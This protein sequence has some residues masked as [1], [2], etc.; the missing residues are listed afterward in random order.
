MDA[1]CFEPDASIWLDSW[2][3][4]ST[5]ENPKNEYGETH[6]IQYDFGSVR[7]LSKSWAWN[8]NDPNR[9][10]QGFNLV[11]VDYSEDGNDWTYWGEMNFPKAQ[12]DAVYGGF[13]GPDLVNIEAR[14]VLLTV[15]STHG[16]STCASL[17][18][19]KFNLLPQNPGEGTAGA[20][21][22]L[23]PVEAFFVEGITETEAYIHWEYDEEFEGLYFVF[24]FKL[25]GEDEE[26]TEFV[27]EDNEAFLDDLEPGTTYEFR[28]TAECGRIFKHSEIGTFTTL[29]GTTSTNG[30]DDNNK[31]TVFPNPASGQFTLQVESESTDLLNYVVRNTQGKQI[32]AVQ[33][34]ITNGQNNFPL[35]LT[36]YPDGVYLLE[37]FTENRQEVVS[38]KMVKLG[39]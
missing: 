8:V 7:R 24:E 30:L 28:I 21:A 19:V 15:V 20:C 1:Q 23:E 22:L 14:Y 29:G 6:W 38:Q 39:K 9:L 37:V 5:T 10:D 26:W 3:S 35:D 17:S 11:K 36:N 2:V 33:A 4:C 27:V 16:S 12:G 25:E 32:M 34:N 18:E 13:P 31:F